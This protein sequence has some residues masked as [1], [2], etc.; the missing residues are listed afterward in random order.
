MKRGRQVHIHLAFVSTHLTNKQIQLFLNNIIAWLNFVSDVA[1]SQCSQTLHIYLILT[2]LKKRLPKSDDD[3]IDT[4]HANTAFTTSC[5]ASNTIFIFRR[6]EWFKVFIHETFHCFGLDFSS[7]IEN[8][9]NKRILSIFPS[10]EPS[11]DIRLYETYCE[12]WAE[13]FNILLCLFVSESG[14]CAK[15]S[16]KRFLDALREEQMFSIKQSN[17]I[18]RRAGLKYSSLFHLPNARQP[19]N[20][21]GKYK[22]NTNAFSYYVIK[23]L[24]LW[25]F[26]KFIQWCVAYSTSGNSSNN[27]PIQFEKTRIGEYCDFIEELTLSDDSYRRIAERQMNRLRRHSE[28]TTLRM[29]ISKANWD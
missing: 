17:K 6:E 10:V 26:E 23:S 24:I 2:N 3:M 11:T 19:S 16:E 20:K 28:D 25:N 4:V 22:E 18:L 12:I 5:S 29:T 1:S 27:I 21:S 14:K 7:S 13:T 8:E 15:F 9:S